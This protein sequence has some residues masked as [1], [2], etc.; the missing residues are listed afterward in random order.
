VC[1]NWLKIEDEVD[2]AHGVAH[3]VVEGGFSEV[4]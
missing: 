2:T 1:R 3:I 4:L